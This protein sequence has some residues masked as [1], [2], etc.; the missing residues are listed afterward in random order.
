MTKLNGWK[1]NCVVFVIFAATAIASPAQTFETLVNFNGPNGATPV[2]PGLVQGLDG[3]LY[4][5][6]LGGGANAMGTVFKMTPG[7]TLTTLY[8]FCSQATCTDGSLPQA[9]LTLAKDGSFY[10]STSEGG[11][12]GDGAIFKITSGGVFAVVHSFD[13]T[14]GAAPFAPP[15]QAS[16]GNFYGTTTSEGGPSN[17]GTV[18]KM[19]PD[20]VLTTLY[21]FKAG[22]G[23]SPL[24]TLIQ[25]TNGDLYG[26]M[27][28]GGG[29]SSGTVF[30]VTLGG[31]FTTIHNFDFS[32]GS[33]PSGL[34]EAVD[35]NLYGTT[36]SGGANSSCGSPGCGTVY[37]ISL[38]GTLTTIYNFDS[39]HGAS[40]I[41]A[42]VQATDKNLYGT[43][44]AGGT[45]TSCGLGCGTVFEITP[46]GVLTT[47]VSFDN[48]DGSDPYGALVQATGGNFYGTTPHGGSGGYSTGG[49]VF[50]LAK[51]S[52]KTALGEQ[53]DYFGEGKADY[54]VWRP[55]DGTFFSLDSSGN[56][57]TKGWGASTDVPLIGDY[58]GDGKT[59]YTVWRPSTGTFYVLQSSNGK[60]ATRGWGA[61]GDIPV[62]GDYD[63]DGKTDF[64]V[65]RPSNA[66]WYVL[67]SSNGKQATRGWGVSTDIPVPG[68]YDGDGKT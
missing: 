40:P 62:P 51:I 24:G 3:N 38:D 46:Q 8:S 7:G 25:A 67:Q 31:A 11:A 19:T 18:F 33:S 50:E 45:S 64:A 55:S 66:T 56:Q 39:T 28:I 9:G 63:G 17:A 13:S 60:Q 10:G 52:E 36:F 57:L 15:I 14:D 20:G 6:T 65:W 58:D 2:Y 48:T 27:Q 1:M 16:D 30:K 54:T 23:S 42:L 22:D 44:S 49:T 53:V 41:S 12:N 32:D 26:T 37:K 4:G 59:D 29:G 34:I 61:K 43:T 35:G 5:T 68:D 47:L 21:G